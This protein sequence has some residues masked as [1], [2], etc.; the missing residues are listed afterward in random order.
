MHPSANNA[1][2]AF[3]LYSSCKL[4]WP[5]QGVARWNHIWTDTYYD[6]ENACIVERRHSLGSVVN[7]HLVC[8]LTTVPVS[9][10]LGLTGSTTDSHYWTASRL[11]C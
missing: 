6:C 4:A 3:Q 9:N 7:K 5:A 8:D 11:L 10:S 1:Q 2:V